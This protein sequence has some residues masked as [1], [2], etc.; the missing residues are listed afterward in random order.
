MPHVCRLSLATAVATATVFLAST[1]A[2]HVLELVHDVL[3][4]Q[5]EGTVGDEV[6]PAAVTTLTE[7]VV[8]SATTVLFVEVC[9]VSHDLGVIDLICHATVYVE[10]IKRVM[11]RGSPRVLGFTSWL[12]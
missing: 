11:A 7:E 1:L 3:E 4:D 12:P 5:H 8:E 6:A 2:L 10:R 9:L